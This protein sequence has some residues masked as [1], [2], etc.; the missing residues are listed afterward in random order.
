MRIEKS[1]GGVLFTCCG[2]SVR[3]LIIRHLGGHCG[4]PKGHMESGETEAQTALREIREEV[5]LTVSLI[6]G[7]RAEDMYPLPRK[8]NTQKHVVYFLAEFS[9]QQVRPQPEEVS[10]VYLLPYEE[11]LA[12]LPFPEA[13]RILT[14]AHQFILQRKENLNY[15]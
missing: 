15:G 3:Y 12:L 5:G 2:G 9:G 1:C 14:E 7:F 8:P 6:D 4:F 10:A 11:A 13:K